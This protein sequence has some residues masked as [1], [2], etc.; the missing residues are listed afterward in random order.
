MRE[1]HEQKTPIVPQFAISPKKVERRCV[2][3]QKSFPTYL[4]QDKIY[5]SRQCCFTHHSNLNPTGKSQKRKR[6]IVKESLTAEIMQEATVAEIATSEAI[7]PG[8]MIE[9]TTAELDELK[10]AV[11]LFVPDAGWSGD[12]KRARIKALSQW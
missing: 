4:C 1:K 3:C 5:C 11:R 8:R 10:F 6:R 2:L 7:Q 12:Q 9:V